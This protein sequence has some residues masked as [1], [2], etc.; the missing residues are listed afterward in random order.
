MDSLLTLRNT[1][2]LQ[3]GVTANTVPFVLSNTR[4]LSTEVY[5]V[6]QSRQVIA[7]SEGGLVSGFSKS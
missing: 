5:D 1:A 4:H 6:S 7:F 2:R 3:G